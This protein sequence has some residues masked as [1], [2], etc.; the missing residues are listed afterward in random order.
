GHRKLPRLHRR[1][2][3]ARAAVARHPRDR[4]SA[5]LSTDRVDVEEGSLEGHRLIASRSF[6]PFSKEPVPAMIAYCGRPTS[7]D[8]RDRLAYI[9]TTMRARRL[10]KSARRGTPS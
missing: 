3:A 2:D 8:F 5:R 6:C 4:V 1:A 7:A 9:V 10:R